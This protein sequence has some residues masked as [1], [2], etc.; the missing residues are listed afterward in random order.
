MAVADGRRVYDATA[1]GSLVGALVDEPLSG[2]IGDAGLSD[3]EL[4][5]LRLVAQGHSNAEVAAELHVSVSTVRTHVRNILTKIGALDR[6]QAVVWAYEH[7]IVA[8][9]R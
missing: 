9:R 5:V 7:R 6:T 2:S 8:P 1:I 4:D 3:R